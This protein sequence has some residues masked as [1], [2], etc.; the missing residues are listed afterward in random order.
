VLI[1]L[2]GRGQQKRVNC[3]DAL[4]VGK[5][6]EA[7]VCAVIQVA[8]RTSLQRRRARGPQHQNFHA[9][10]DMSTLMWTE[11]ETQRT[12]GATLPGVNESAA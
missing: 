10:P 4:M 3:T 9:S 12:G 1:T 8:A 7:V 5:S 11:V 2:E 6:R